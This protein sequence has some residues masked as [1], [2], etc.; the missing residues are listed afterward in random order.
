M[1]HFHSSFSRSSWLFIF[2]VGVF[3]PLTTAAGV[4]LDISSADSIKSA[5][6]RIAFDLVTFYTGNN[7][8]DTP[9]NLPDP[10]YWWEAGAFFGALV[11]YWSY[12][13]DSVY[14][15]ITKQAMIH[16]AGTK[17]DFMPENQTY[18]E[19]NDDQCFWALSAMIAAE[20]NFP[21]PA[22][23]TPGWLAMVQAVFN[24]QAHRWD[25]SACGGGLRWQIYTWNSGYLYRNSIAN[26]CFFDIA[27]RLARYTG[28][29][30]YAKWA[31][32][33]WDWTHVIG[34]IG[35]E[36]EVFDGVFDGVT[37]VD[38]CTSHDHNRWS[39]NAGVWLHG[40]SVMYNYT[41]EHG[42]SVSSTWR[43]RTDSLLKA[44]D[45]FFPKDN[46]MF[47]HNCEASGKCNVDQLSFKAYLSRWLAEVTQYAPYTY[48][49]IMSEKLRPTAVAAV[50]QCQGGDTGTFCGHKWSVGEYD[51]TTGVGQ[52]MGV[53]EVLQ[54]LLAA[55]VG[56]ALTSSTGGES[57]GNSAAG[58]GDDETK[59]ELPT[60]HIDNGDR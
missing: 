30:T 35:N 55:D 19:G 46:I 47:E 34:L 7:T 43:E 15:D 26:G 57:E 14:N 31:T 16:Q 2:L 9:G 13:G 58:T 29:D 49:A 20:R 42:S 40:A 10:Y 5:A 8:G 17:G 48:D 23:P 4:S 11:N 32:K 25:T 33:A 59:A 54:G 45:H 39:Y 41:A 12:T 22:S 28:N 44:A 51:G 60:M 38:N 6:S 27:S 56:G 18:T 24:E 36:Y 3:G 1:L 37:D 52:Q 50:A 21:A 53:L